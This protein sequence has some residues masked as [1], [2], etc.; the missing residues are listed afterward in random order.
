MSA[1]LVYT[2]VKVKGVTFDHNAK[3]F[4]TVSLTCF[5]VKFLVGRYGGLMK[6][7]RLLKRR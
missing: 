4:H 7:V 2:S 3:E 1:L 6:Y 5:L